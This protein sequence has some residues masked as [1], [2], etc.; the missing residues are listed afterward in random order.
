MVRLGK[1]GNK[2]TLSGQKVHYRLYMWIGAGCCYFTPFFPFHAVV[3]TRPPPVATTE[4]T[5]M[6]TDNS[7]AT[8][9]MANT[10]SPP[11]T[12]PVHPVLLANTVVITLAGISVE[13]VSERMIITCLV[14]GQGLIQR[15]EAP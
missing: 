12:T 1:G 11:I 7:V 5:T 10:E 9:S 2:V 3:T 8:A 4:A 6:L 14:Y 15:G 13:E